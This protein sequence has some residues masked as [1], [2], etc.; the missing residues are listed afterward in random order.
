M[1]SN[2]RPSRPVFYATNRQKTTIHNLKRKKG[3]DDDTYR[4]TIYSC[5]HGRTDSSKY[6]Y[7]YE[8][9][10]LIQKWLDPE[11]KNEKRQKEQKEVVG[12]IYGLSFSIGILNK[13]YSSDDPNEVEMNKAKISSFLKKRGAIKK[14][15]GQQNLEELKETLKQLQTIKSK[16]GK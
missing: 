10:E 3:L 16:E 2:D 12:D 8:A 14:E 15:I 1:K 13:G 7:R 4:A 9:A 6:M 5:T 11:G